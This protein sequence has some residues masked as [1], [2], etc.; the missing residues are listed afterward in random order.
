MSQSMMMVMLTIKTQL[1]H[2]LGYTTVSGFHYTKE[3]TVITCI[4]ER[5]G[6][7]NTRFIETQ[8]RT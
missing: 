5:L 1:L 6:F 2:T 3:L 7:Q 8:K 4:D